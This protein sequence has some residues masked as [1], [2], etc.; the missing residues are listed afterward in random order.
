MGREYHRRQVQSGIYWGYIA[1]IEGMVA[2]I[3][4]G[5]WWAAEGDRDRRPGAAAGRGHQYHRQ[6]STLI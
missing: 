1:M 2:R 5:V 6:A 4:G 3:Q